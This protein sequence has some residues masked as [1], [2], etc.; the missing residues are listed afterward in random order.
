VSAQVR[1][2]GEGR[3]EEEGVARVARVVDGIWILRVCMI[4]MA[5]VFVVFSGVLVVLVDVDV[6]DVAV[7]A[8]DM[9]NVGI[10]SV[11]A[12]VAVA[13]DEVFLVGCV[14]YGDLGFA[15]L[16]CHTRTII[17]GGHHQI[18]QTIRNQKRRLTTTNTSS[19]FRSPIPLSMQ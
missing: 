4:E 8:R 13:G 12:V 9:S 16:V 18:N 19:L 17:D 5:V 11:P 6:V 1:A 3:K 15:V 7:G 14:E 2:Q 10:V